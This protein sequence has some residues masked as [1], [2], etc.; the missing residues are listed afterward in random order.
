[1]SAKFAREEMVRFINGDQPEVLCIYGGWGVGKTFAWQQAVSAQGAE[2]HKFCGEYSYVSL[3]GLS[4]IDEVKGAIFSRA[5]KIVSAPNVWTSQS[6][7]RALDLIRKHSDRIPKI[8]G[9]FGG[10]G[11]ALASVI[12]DMKFDAVKRYLICFD[13][14]ERMSNNISLGDLLGLANYLRDERECK[15]CLLLNSDQLS[16]INKQ[17]FE[18]QFEKVVD[19]YLKYEPN[20]DELV[21]IALKDEALSKIYGDIISSLGIQN[22]R[23][24]KKS[25]VMADRVIEDLE[26]H[27]SLIDQVISTILIS[28]YIKFSRPEIGLNRLKL[29]TI[30]R[31]IDENKEPI[32]YELKN[33]C[34]RIGYTL[35][36]ALD[37]ILI[38]AVDKGFL[39][40]EALTRSAEEIV[41][42]KRQ[43]QRAD[44]LKAAWELYHNNLHTA[45][46]DLV[47]NFISAIKD[48]P[49]IV[50]IS[51]FNSVVSVVRW[52]GGDHIAD[53]LIKLYF[54]K[55]GIGI[56]EINEDVFLGEHEPIDPGVQLAIDGVRSS[57]VDTRNPSDVLSSMA[58]RS[59]WNQDDILLLES[60]QP[61]QILE[62]LDSK[63]G[64]ELAASLN[65]AVRVFRSND[66]PN[67]SASLKAAG[68]ELA[69]RS[70]RNHRW[71]ERLGLIAQPALDPPPESA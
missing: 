15:I 16:G 35:S 23:I 40:E 67:F 31:H 58:E 24:I 57:F 21:E 52:L 48:D 5:R 12:D 61:D 22:L 46:S 9:F 68:A 8:G 36:D 55:S 45:D 63:E 50:S 65:M 32:E 30:Y 66:A 25:K 53:E 14:I 41:S 64:E 19:E 3:F 43:G 51:S 1:M 17:I 2:N 26:V 39:D 11:Q 6:A 28:S 20:S 49:E 7:D 44:R 18:N 27:K 70:K 13:D 54:E 56:V 71:M 29:F 59:G 10:K 37:R 34:D 69:E 4:S 42:K 60:L 33:I 47:E 62:I 38:D